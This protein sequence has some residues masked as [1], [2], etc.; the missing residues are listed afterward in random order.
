VTLLYCVATK[1]PISSRRKVFLIRCLLEL[2]YLC[3]DSQAI[4]TETCLLH[5]RL[6]NMHII[7]LP[8]C[9]L[10]VTLL[11]LCMVLYAFFSADI[12]T[13]ALLQCCT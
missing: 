1:H 12:L 3:N 11:L 6:V 5:I 9:V 4:C 8:A 13:Y 7:V 2:V 10:A